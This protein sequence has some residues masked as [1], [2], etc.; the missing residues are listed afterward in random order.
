VAEFHL[1]PLDRAHLALVRTWLA[2]EETRDLVGTRMMPSDAQHERWFESLQT[3]PTRMAF[4]VA[5]AGA[6]R[7]LG[8][9]GLSGIDRVARSAEL[10]LYV[11]ERAKRG[12]GVGRV[13][14]RE[15][16]RMA[17]GTQGLHRIFVRVFGY[18]P[19]AHAFFAA[20]GFVDEG[21]ERA[22]AFRHGRFH[23]VWRMALLADEHR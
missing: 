15:L 8:I 7:P 13:A 16:L 23:D 20:L 9:V 11:G 19:G 1:I 10:W 6:E 17:F 21:I 22:G 3:D 18:N 14:V 5:E 4:L 2:D 12:L